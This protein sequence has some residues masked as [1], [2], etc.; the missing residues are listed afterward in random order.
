VKLVA[1]IALILL[2]AAPTLACSEAGAWQDAI[3][4]AVARTDAAQSY[5]F[6]ENSTTQDAEGCTTQSS[7][8]A[9]YSGGDSHSSERLSRF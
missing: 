1:A 5:R 4:R 9:E 7:F 6:A 3:A 8:V 2:L